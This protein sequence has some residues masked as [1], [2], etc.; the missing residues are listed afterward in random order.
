MR[1]TDEQMHLPEAPAERK[2][3]GPLRWLLYAVGLA[4]LAWCIYF[5][6]EGTR[7]QTGQSGF[8]RLA[9]ADPLDIAAIAGLVLVQIGLNGI[10]FCWLTRPFEKQRPVSI[11]D[12]TA[13]IAATSLLNYLPMRAGL[14]GRAAYLKQRHDLDYRVS[15]LMMLMV[16]GGTVGVFILLGMVTL[17]RVEAGVDLLWWVCAAVGLIIGGIAALPAGKLL[18]QF[19]PGVSNRWFRQMTA[20]K[21]AGATLLLSL[22]ALDV[23]CNAGRL[24]LAA[25]VLGVPLALPTAIL[26]AIGG[27]FVTLATPLPNGLGLREGLYGLFARAGLG[28]DLL[29]GSAGISI[30]LV[31]RAAEAVVFIVTGLAALAY[32][33]RRTQIT[34]NDEERNL[35]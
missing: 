32:L 28:E 34:A 20:G 15:M 23:L 21:V 26:M 3:R 18:I 2:T 6:I 19:I 10:A 33:H 25:K 1:E 27:M 11:R 13:L 31:D 22:R 30:G 35:E 29:T 4:L 24:Y 7:D 9:D 16:A 17:W 5:A 14:I 12:M 8:A